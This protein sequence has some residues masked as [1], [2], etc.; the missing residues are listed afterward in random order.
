MAPHTPAPPALRLVS[1][2]ALASPP[3][4]IPAPRLP[5]PGD[6]AY[7]SV[8]GMKLGTVTRL[9]HDGGL[10]I[11]TAPDAHGRTTERRQRERD[12]RF[13]TFVEPLAACITRVRNNT[14]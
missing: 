12:L 7:S 3:P 13:I 11:T 10:T 5:R 6:E 9:H 14:L 2:R 8:S 1:S 4:A